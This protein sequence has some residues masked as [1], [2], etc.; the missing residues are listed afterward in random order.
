MAMADVDLALGVGGV[1]LLLLT[2]DWVTTLLLAKSYHSAV[3]L[4][5]A[6]AIGCALQALGTVVAQPLLANK[7][8]RWMLLGRVAG[9]LTAVIS[10]PVLVS[11]FG[12]MGA[13]LA[14]PLYFGV[15]AL[16]LATLAKPWQI[17]SMEENDPTTTSENATA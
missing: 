5:P 15:E 11:Q 17:T 1:C 12:L 2:K 13:A 10:I 14:N 9:V 16:V 4:M 3:E 7:Q 8:T 6:I